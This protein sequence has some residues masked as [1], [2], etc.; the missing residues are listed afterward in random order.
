[1]A[2]VKVADGVGFARSYTFHLWKDSADLA[3]KLRAILAESPAA[4]HLAVTMTGE[5]ADC[6]ACKADG[7]R[8][9]LDAVARGSDNRHTRVYLVDGRLVSPVVAS[10]HPHLAAASNW[11]ALAQ[12]AGRYAR[13]AAAL[14]VDVGSTTCDIIPLIDGRPAA[15]GRSDTQR[16]IAG[17]LVYTGVERSPVCAV[18]SHAPYR[19]QTCPVTQELFATMLD[20]YLVLD[21]LPEDPANHHTADSRPA[22]KAAAV[23]RLGRMLAAD[24]SEFDA[25]DATAIAEAAA[26]SQ[27]TLVAAAITQVVAQ[28]ASRPEQ[29]ILSGHGDF[30]ATA[31]LCEARIDAPLVRLSQ[32]LDPSLARVGPAHALAVL[33]REAVAP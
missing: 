30:L 29:V 32:Q 23:A 28:A 25:S 20:V 24:A 15:T 33:A 22:T 26:R 11:R 10:Q 17:E 13:Q 14:L 31:A 2:N 3:S 16:L 21:R 4:D 27:A 9:I 1:G 8:F 19:G 12:F 6:F 18:V 7:V 5:L